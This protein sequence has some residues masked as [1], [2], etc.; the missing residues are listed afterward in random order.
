MP[1]TLLVTDNGDAT[2][3]SDSELTASLDI[4]D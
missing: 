4:V 2:G 3:A 1:L